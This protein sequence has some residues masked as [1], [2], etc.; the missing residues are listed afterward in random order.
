[1]SPITIQEANLPY[2]VDDYYTVPVG[3]IDNV[4]AVV[5]TDETCTFYRYF[6]TIQ[7]GSGTK[8]DNT[9][10]AVPARKFL[11]NGQLYILYNGIMY[12]VQGGKVNEK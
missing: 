3:A 11:R 9:D 5:P 12:N 1:M 8:T 7:K 4:I 6:I 2:Q 10:D